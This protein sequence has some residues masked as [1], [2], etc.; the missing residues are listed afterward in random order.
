[1]SEEFVSE[2][3]EPVEGSGNPT[4]MVKGEPGF[5][6]RFFWRGQEYELAEI[7]AA[8]K[9]DGLCKSGGSEKYLRKHWYRISTTNGYEMKIYFERQSRSKPQAKKRW[10]LYTISPNR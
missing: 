2:Q 3:I 1:M 4:G 5:P 6:R 7:Q 9:E 8:W 10:W